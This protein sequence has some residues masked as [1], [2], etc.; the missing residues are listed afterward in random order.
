MPAAT[1]AAKAV[2]RIDGHIRFSGPQSRRPLAALTYASRQITTP[3]APRPA[4]LSVVVYVEHPPRTSVEPRRVEMRQEDESFLPAVLPV[5]VGSTVEFT[6]E[7]DYFHNVFSLSHGASFDLGRYPR[8]E[9]RSRVFTH[10]GV[11]KVFCHIHS[12]M[13]GVIVVFDHPYFTMPDEEG[14]FVLDGLPPGSYRV[15]AWHER[16][17]EAST[18][19]TVS[20]G[21]P[22]H[23]EIALP[24]VAE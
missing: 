6:N 5:T 16:V 10:A 14:T 9:S 11:V 22:A 7:D 23:A 17:G 18:P 4:I 12:H 15:A 1:V 21:E 19:V 20:A 8:G 3:A 13:H 2:G 24:M